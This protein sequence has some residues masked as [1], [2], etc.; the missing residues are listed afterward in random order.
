MPK[1]MLKGVVVSNKS[2]KTIVVEVERYC[3]HKRYLKRIKKSKRYLVHDESNVCFI[4]QE[5]T[6][7]ESLPL[8]KNKNWIVVS[9]SEAA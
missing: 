4:G 1:R 3:M 9:L 2:D 5:V 8:S 6:I 7:Y